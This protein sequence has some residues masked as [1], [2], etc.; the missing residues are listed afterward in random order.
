MTDSEDEPL[1]IST[2][3]QAQLWVSAFAEASASRGIT[4]EAVLEVAWRLTRCMAVMRGLLSPDQPLDTL[5]P[6]Q[7]TSLGLVDPEGIT[8]TSRSPLL[9]VR[10]AL[11]GCP[12]SPVVLD[13]QNQQGEVEAFLVV[14]AAAAEIDELRWRSEPLDAALPYL[15][16]GA[17]DLFDPERWPTLA[18]LVEHEDRRVEAVITKLIEASLNGTRAWLI[19]EQLFSRRTARALA[20]M[21]LAHLGRAMRADREDRRG[22]M[23]AR[24]E[25]VAERARGALNLNAEIQAL[26]LMGTVEGLTASGQ[27]S[28]DEEFL[29]V[30]ARVAKAPKQL[31]PAKKELEMD[32]DDAIPRIKVSTPEPAEHA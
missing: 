20:A 32:I 5:T 31:G 29:D 4:E 25:S 2:L 19:E 24:L 8:E 21:A 14:A 13:P 23:V 16:P 26:R 7:G 22:L 28:E 9:A 10:G 27:A 15:L 11:R 18:D 30:V 1:P 17:W 3:S 6:A 12:L